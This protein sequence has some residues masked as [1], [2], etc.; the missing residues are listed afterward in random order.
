MIKQKTHKKIYENKWLT[1]W[2][3]DIEFPDGD[4]GIYAYIERKT[5]GA[6]IIPVDKDGNIYMI[7]GPRYPLNLVRYGF[8]Q[9]DTEEGETRFESAKR[10]LKEETGITAE[11]WQELGEIQIDPGYVVQKTPIYFAEELTLG[12]KDNNPKEEWT[13]HKVSPEEVSTFIVEG[14]IATGWAL[15]ALAL[16]WNYQASSS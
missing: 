16:L 9:G 4:K 15:S 5:R 3:D 2:E 10:E 1:L 8:P 6:L 13:L 7:S 14:K 11:K 12:E